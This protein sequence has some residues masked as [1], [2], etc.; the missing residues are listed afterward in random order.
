M[1]AFISLN[2]QV[3]ENFVNISENECPVSD[4][5]EYLLG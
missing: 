1:L 3:P 5:D 4:R 2:P